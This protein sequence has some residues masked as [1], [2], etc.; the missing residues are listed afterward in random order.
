MQ[1][2]LPP[3]RPQFLEVVRGILLTKIVAFDE[4]APTMHL[5]QKPNQRISIAPRQLHGILVYIDIKNKILNGSNCRYIL[6]LLPRPYEQR[7][8]VR[9]PA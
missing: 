8:N 3:K 4:Y 7:S 9:V 5:Q 2:S 6:L 1:L